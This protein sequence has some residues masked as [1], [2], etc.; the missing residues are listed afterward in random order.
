VKAVNATLPFPEPRI[1]ALDLGAAGRGGAYLASPAAPY[2]VAYRIDSRGML[3]F[4]LDERTD[5]AAARTLL[6]EVGAYAA[7]LLD[8]L[9]RGRLAF[10][11]AGAAQGG[12]PSALLGN[13]GGA[14]GT[15]KLTVL[16]EDS[17]GTR[18]VIET[19]DLAGPIAA[20]ARMGSVAIPRGATRLVA[21]FRGLDALG[22]PIVVVEDAPLPLR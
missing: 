18:R 8:H 11:P 3:S 17:R 12:R 1:R 2:L 22:E 16:A 15:G 21:V 19:R 4:W 5:R 7:G 14:L 9:F 20:N 13:Q 6:P 10:T